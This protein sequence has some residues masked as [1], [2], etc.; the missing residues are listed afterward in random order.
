LGVSEG[1]RKFKEKWGG[2]PF[3]KYESCSY[4]TGYTGTL[5]RFKAWGV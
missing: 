3:L 2:V 4:D 5:E 1:I